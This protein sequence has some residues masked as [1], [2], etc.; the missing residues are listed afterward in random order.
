MYSG[1]FQYP[2]M[3]KNGVLRRGGKPST[4]RFRGR[5]AAA[6]AFCFPAAFRVSNL[7]GG[8][9]RLAKKKDV[10]YLETSFSRESYS[11]KRHSDIDLP[12]DRSPA[13]LT[14]GLAADRFPRWERPPC[15]RPVYVPKPGIRIE[16]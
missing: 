16:K 13:R 2:P 11:T 1:L 6:E 15:S 3:R 14:Y 9:N 5:F 12:H 4:S 7:E 10:V 8:K